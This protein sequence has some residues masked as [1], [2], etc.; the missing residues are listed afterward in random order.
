MQRTRSTSM[1]ERRVP[2]FRGFVDRLPTFLLLH[3]LLITE[4][5]DDVSRVSANSNQLM[6]RHVIG[7]GPASFYHLLSF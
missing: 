1:Y 7:N 4:M 3:L 6:E 2:E 5:I